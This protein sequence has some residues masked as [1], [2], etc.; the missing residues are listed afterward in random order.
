[1]KKIFSFLIYVAFISSTYALPQCEGDDE[2]R[3]QNCEGIL[4]SASGG[5]YVGVFRNGIFDGEYALMGRTYVGEYKNGTMHGQGTMMVNGFG[6]VGEWK[7]GKNHGQG[8][9]TWAK[10]GRKYVG[11]WKDGLRHGQGTETLS[12][13]GRKYVGGWENNKQHGEGAYTGADGSK[14][15]GEWK[16][17]EKHGRGTWTWA[18]GDKHVGEWKDDKRNGE[19]TETLVNGDKYVGYW[20]EG[21]GFGPATFI[22]AS[23]DEIEGIWKDGEF[24]GGDFF[25][26]TQRDDYTS[27]YR[28]ARFAFSIDYPRNIFL[29]GPEPANGGGIT[30]TSLDGVATLDVWGGNA[31]YFD[32][33]DQYGDLAVEYKELLARPNL[34]ITHKVI[35]DKWFVV[36]GF[37]GENIFYIKQM[38]LMEDRSS[39]QFAKF[40]FK[41]PKSSS[42][43]Y[44][45][46]TKIFSKSFKFLDE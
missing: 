4:T 26:E 41:Y 37:E 30:M 18:N 46:V 14:Y 22:F 33:E 42:K 5:E 12:K 6:Y 17:G 7:D 13:H 2:R 35:K 43:L 28:N 19:G 10:H 20:R 25:A 38:N 29:P 31:F 24:L 15:V 3:W 8:T 34:K 23:G 11:E 32:D 21:K 16:D 45:P 9:W 1:M 27:T 36:S 40:Y 44:N 39:G